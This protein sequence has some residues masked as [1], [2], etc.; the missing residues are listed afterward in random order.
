M[1][2]KSFESIFIDLKFKNKIVTCGVVHRS[3]QT[4]SELFSEF[5][6]NLLSTLSKLNIN[7]SDCYIIGDFNIDLLACES[8]YTE[9]YTDIML[10]SNFYPLINKPTRVTTTR[11]SGIDHIWTNITGARI[12][13]AILTHKIADHLPIMQVSNIGE[14]LLKIEN[15]GWAITTKNLQSFCRNLE[16]SDFSE[17]CTLADPNDSF[18]T[19][20]NKVNQ[21]MLQCFKNE[22]PKKTKF[23]CEWYNK[24]LPAL[25]RK[26][27]QLHKRFLAKQ[28]PD[29]KQ[30]Y[31][32]IK[33]FYFHLITIKK[34]AFMQKKFHLHKSDIKRTWQTMNNSLGRAPKASGS[35]S[36]EVD[37]NL[38]SDPIELA[39][40][41]NEHFATVAE[42]LVRKLPNSN[43][44][45]TDYLTSSNSSSI[46][47]TPT[48]QFEIKKIISAFASKLSAGLD[49]IP[50]IIM[51]YF[52]DNAIHALSY[53]FNQS[54][55]LGKF[56]EAFKTAKIVPV[57]KN[58]SR[59]KVANYRP[60]SLLSSFSKILEKIKYK[61]LHS[62]I[63]HTN[64]FSS[65]QFGFRQNHS[66]THATTLFIN[67]IVDAFEK[68]QS[69]LG[70]FL[71]LS[72]AFDTIDHD[73]LLLKLIHYDVRGVS[74]EWFKSYLT[75]R[76]QKVECAGKLSSN[77]R[78]SSVPH[79]SILGPLL[80]LIYVNDFQNCVKFSSNVSFA[81]DTNVFLSGRNIQS[82]YDQ[83]NKKLSNIDNWVLANK[84]TVNVKKT[85]CILFKTCNPCKSRKAT[86]TSELKLRNEVIARVSSIRFLGVTIHEN[87]T[88]KHHMYAVKKKMR[89][90]LGAVMRIRSFL[91]KRAMLTLYHSLILSYVYKYLNQCLP[92]ALQNLISIKATRITT[93]SYSKYIPPSYR[94]TV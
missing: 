29:S 45:I 8:Q 92:A 61:R 6:D 73:P 79:G 34:K 78:A 77:S 67:N 80:F 4:N 83:G 46:F 88:W 90:A 26:K 33:N 71:D 7:N 32:K 9:T 40:A 62:F 94:A 14:P 25:S 31:Q 23:R 28:T 56:I 91:N 48:S 81:D 93:R 18:E 55:S 43:A 24:E 19:F 1:K 47:M 11:C 68:R 57:F 20:M 2:E 89:A 35:T 82:V 66:T 5:T 76:K 64:N 49:E 22:K 38:V 42:K 17:V 51:K 3:P 41:F 52:P 65:Q 75:G 13:S 50:M 74:L 21:Q 59:K 44:K 16:N 30:K 87:L 69:V 85:K 37:G 54:L 53:I 86:Q 60:I 39:D 84:L 72:K 12:Q 36:L 70:I 10:D 63:T 58:G 27:D 15:K